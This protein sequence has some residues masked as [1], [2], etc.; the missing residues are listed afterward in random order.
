MVSYKIDELM[1]DASVQNIQNHLH[2]VEILIL[3]LILLIIPM[4]L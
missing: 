3:I 2:P 4:W 1:V